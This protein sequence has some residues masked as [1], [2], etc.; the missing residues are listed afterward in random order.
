MAVDVVPNVSFLEF[1]Y[2]DDASPQVVPTSMDDV[3]NVEITLVVRP[4]VIDASYTNTRIYTNMQGTT[5]Y[6]AP[7]DNFR[8]K[9]LT[10]R[11]KARNVGLN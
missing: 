9:Q 6:T 7:G 8:R 3:R 10:A 4:A 1:L 2:Y 5:I 11:V